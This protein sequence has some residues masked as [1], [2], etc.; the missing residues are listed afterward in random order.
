MPRK[1]KK[2]VGRPFSR[3][4]DPRRHPLTTEERSRGG[5]TAVLRMLEE[6]PWMLDWLTRR[7]KATARPGTVA[8]YNLRRRRGEKACG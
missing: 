5:K 7:I 3:G 1:P 2:V 8:A 6:A 4:P